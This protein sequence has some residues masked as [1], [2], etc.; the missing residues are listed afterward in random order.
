MP[1]PILILGQGLAGSLLAW[2]FERAGID[3]EIVDQGHALAS[4]RIGAGIINPIT[5]QR[6]VKSWR[7]DALLPGA[8]ETY[9][10]MERMLGVSLVREMRVKRFFNDER[11]RR[12]FAEKSASGELAPYAGVTE[13]DG[14]W[15][16]GAAQ[17]HTAA[18]IAAMRA[19]L[20]AAGR[21]REDRVAPLEVRSRYDLVI[22]CAGV[23]AGEDEPA[24]AFGFANLRPAKGETLTVSATNAGELAEDV[25]LNAGH[26]L[27]PLGNGLAR[28]GATFEPGVV[29]LMGSAAARSVLEKSAAR[30]LASGF[31]VVAHE[32]GLRMTSA[33]K[34]PVVGRSAGDPGL[35][36]FNGLGSKGALL[37]P[38]LARQWVNHLTEAVPFDA[39]VDVRRFAKRGG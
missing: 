17:V 33:D 31:T 7:V 29:D 4:S 8:L 35:G 19:R 30:F 22:L 20:V 5:G 15:I 27:L 18:L 6:L 3:F 12:I 39:A 38:G 37:A 21:L 36:I 34:H 25:I 13:M 1:A 14:F 10:A 9:R 24:E 2:E 26:W 32:V 28:V 16:K 11:E 23:F